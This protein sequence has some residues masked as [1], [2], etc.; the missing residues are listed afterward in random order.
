MKNILIL[1]FLLCFVGEMNAQTIFETGS[2]KEALAKARKEK[3]MVLIVGSA[4]WCGPCQALKKN[5]FPMEKVGDYFNPRFVVKT[6]ELDKADPDNIARTYNIT[7]YPTLL[8]LNGEG[9]ELTR[10]LGGASDPD[11]FVGMIQKAIQPENLLTA[12]AER[13]RHDPT[14]GIAYIRFLQDSCYKYQEAA[15][16][17]AE[18]FQRRS[19]E[20]NFNTESMA[21]YETGVHDVNSVVITYMLEHPKIVMEIIGEQVYEDF[22]V[23]KANNYISK[24][25][26]APYFDKEKY[27]RGIQIVME[28]KQLRTSYVIF[29]DEIKEAWIEKNY[30]LVFKIADK[31]LEKTDTRNR[32][33]IATAVRMLCGRD[34]S[35]ENLEA[36]IKMYEACSCYE[37]DKVQRETYQVFKS[38]TESMLNMRSKQ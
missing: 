19:V 18:L 11:V 9:K 31:Y 20:E 5:I 36:L 10:V 21:F 26:F 4:T 22:L 17:L 32:L 27:W 38:D 37:S 29:M 14:Y 35:I 25:A 33:A 8:I 28:K 6:Y 3:K 13:F 30:P 12:R 24:L 16:A 1:F 23:K 15:E 34:V 7:A 2:L